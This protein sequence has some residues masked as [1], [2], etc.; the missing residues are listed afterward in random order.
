MRSVPG[1]GRKQEQQIQTWMQSDGERHSWRDRQTDWA[2]GAHTEAGERDRGSRRGDQLAGCYA[3]T[4]GVLTADRERREGRAGER[5]AGD[6][7]PRLGVP[8]PRMCLNVTNTL[9]D[10]ELKVLTF[11][12]SS[13]KWIC[14]G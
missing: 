3:G 11:T 7:E 13:E 4:R 10:S 6:A 5:R 1:E 9:P 12:I 14:A 8:P 2:P